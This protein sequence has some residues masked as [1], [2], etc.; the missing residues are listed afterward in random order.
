MGFNDEVRDAVLTQSV[1]SQRFASHMQKRIDTLWDGMEGDLQRLIA[2]VNTGQGVTSGAIKKQIRGGLATIKRHHQKMEEIVGTQMGRFANFSSNN[3][4][5]K[6]NDLAGIE[7]FQKTGDLRALS[8]KSMIVGQP[9]GEWWG[10]Q[11]RAAQNKFTQQMRLGVLAGDSPDKMVSRLL[12]DVG[13]LKLN[14]AQAK[15]LVRTSAASINNNALLATFKAN[16]DVIEAVEADAT[17]DARTTDICIGRDGGIWDLQTGAAT[18]DSAVQTSWPGPPPWHIQCRTT[19]TPV[20]KSFKE[21]AKKAGLKTNKIPKGTRATMDGQIPESMSAAKWLKRKGT[22]FGSDLLGKARHQ[23]WQDGKI[24]LQQL[25]DQSGRSLNLPQLTRLA[26]G[27]ST[28][29]VAKATLIKK[30]VVQRAQ[31]AQAAPQAPRPGQTPTSDYLAQ[32]EEYSRVAPSDQV[33]SIKSYTRSFK[34]ANRVRRSQLGTLQGSDDLIELYG[35]MAGDIEAFIANAPKQNIDLHRG[36]NFGTAAE[37]DQFSFLKRGAIWEDGAVSSWSSSKAVANEFAKGGGKFTDLAA[38]KHGKFEVVLR[39]RSS[40][41]GGIADRISAIDNQG[42]HLMPSG[43]RFQVARIKRTTVGEKVRIEVLLED[44]TSSKVLSTKKSSTRTQAPR[45]GQAPT[46]LTADHP[47]PWTT[48]EILGTS[49]KE[50]DAFSKDLSHRRAKVRR[51]NKKLRELKPDTEAYGK[52]LLKRDAAVKDFD[53][54]WRSLHDGAPPPTMVI[55]KPPPPPPKPKPRPKPAA[56]APK[57]KAGEP[58]TMLTGQEVRE[59]ILALDDAAN[60]AV[61]PWSDYLRARDKILKQ[62]GLRSGRNIK[63]L[64]TDALKEVKKLQGATIRRSPIKES[65]KLLEIPK[66]SQT[67]VVTERVT[68]KQFSG[69]VIERPLNRTETSAIKFIESI[70]ARRTVGRIRVNINERAG[71]RAYANRAKGS[72]RNAAHSIVYTGT[73]KQV[74]IHELGHTIEFSSSNV[75]TKLN[76]HR[77]ARAAADPRGVTNMNRLYPGRGYDPREAT[78][79]DKWTDPYQ[80]IIYDGATELMS[81]GVEF[82]FKDPVKFARSD[83]DTFDLIVNLLRGHV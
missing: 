59:R 53:R 48:D 73:K 49:L 54:F 2:K 25:T 36:M 80:G 33:Q 20:V 45:P 50:V 46:S 3:I 35:D 56:A 31:P 21:L 71:V 28:K 51:T 81:M 76:K 67:T 10:R 66:G 78:H 60:N 39:V 4:V 68:V 38:Q 72:S 44:V 40:R 6:I 18:K 14:K 24:T 69:K 26:A 42:E 32:V 9:A 15:A 12:K 19:I 55:T 74:L 11:T 34:T 27:K 43:G 57:P 1:G 65:H 13:S 62:H 7:L 23:L 8:T 64:P 52:M 58:T 83:P 41:A 29:Q 82:L 37:L 63:S 70:T 61:L 30:A 16:S 22:K 17:L 79:R 47:N 77:R 75:F 5:E